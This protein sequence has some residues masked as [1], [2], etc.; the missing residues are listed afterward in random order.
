[1]AAKSTANSDFYQ[2]ADGSYTR[3]TAA[4]TINYRDSAGTWQPID[5]SVVKGAGG[6][7]QEKANSLAVDFAPSAADPA[8]VHVSLDGSHGLTYGLAGAAPSAPA[9]SGSTATYPSVL[10]ATDLVVAPTAIG[11]EESLILHSASAPNQWTFPLALTGL[12]PIPAKD[13]SIDLVTAS[14]R[15][16]AVIPPA[17][18]HDSKVNRVSGEP[19]QTSAISY[20]LATA[21]GSPALVVTLDPAW[22]HAPSRV[23]PVTVDPSTLNVQGLSTY[24]ESTAPGD[25][26]TENVIKVGSYNAGPDSA[27]SFL[28]FPGSGLDGSKATISSAS[29]SLF[30]TW[31]STCTPERFDVAAVKTTWTPSSI[32]SYPG[33][34]YGASIGNATPNVPAACAN[35]GADRSVGNTVTVP[36]ATA[37]LQ[38]WANGTTPDYGLA[39]Y[40]ST[41]DALHWKQFGS[42]YDPGGVPYLTVTYT[43]VLLPR[44]LSQSP[45]DGD[46]VGTLTPQLTVAGSVDVADVGKLKFDFQVTNA[47][48]TKVADSG[49]VSGGGGNNG[50]AAWT[51]PSGDLAWGQGYY[52]T[53]QAYDGTNYSPGAVWNALQVQV[54]QPLITSSLSQN[55]GKQ[56]FDPSIGNYTHEATDAQVSSPGPALSVV[57]DYNSRDPRTSGAFGAAWSSVFD[58]RATEQYNAAGAVASVVVTYPDG[59]QVGYG[60]NPSGSFSPPEGRFATFKS[61]T[62]G[63]A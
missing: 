34:S 2:N 37:T 45:A 11:A 26:S 48:G 8:L 62:G 27:D 60:K 22:L 47:S 42:V 30:D 4:G 59:S 3:R 54:P 43:G 46:I 7:W 9:V 29:L 63:T 40:A 33:P 32:T 35:T 51:I 61:V 13:G 18:A 6:R 56:G 14:G 55:S 53:V 19:A 15:S 16:M 49:L 23:F 10:P 12:S 21:G 28:Q 50:S 52:W 20:Q 31:A 5:T 36:L 25:H 44:V 58:A 17:Y 57:R 24:A 39:V 41:T 38:A 1:M